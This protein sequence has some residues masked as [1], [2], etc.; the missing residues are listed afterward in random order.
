MRSP[1]LC[2]AWRTKGIVEREIRGV[3]RVAES[4][5]LAVAR[6][7]RTFARVVLAGLLE[8]RPR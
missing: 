7:V 5:L 6:G 2:G 3:C 4:E 1:D 8:Y